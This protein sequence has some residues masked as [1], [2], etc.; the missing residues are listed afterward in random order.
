MKRFIVK[1]FIFTFPVLL[2]FTIEGFLPSSVFTWRPWEALLFNYYRFSFG[3]VFYPYSDLQ[4]NTVGQLCHHTKY[5]ITKMEKW[6]TDKSGNRNDVFIEDPDIL[7]IGDSFVVGGA[8]TQDSTFTKQLQY[9]LGDSLKV[10]NIAPAEFSVLDYYLK[11]KIIKKPKLVIFARSERFI[12]EAMEIYSEPDNSMKSKIKAVLLDNDLFLSSCVF[13]DKCFRMYSKKWIQ[14]RMSGQKGNGLAGIEESNMFFYNTEDNIVLPNQVTDFMEDMKKTKD[15]IISF[16]AYCDSLDID[17]LFLPMPNKASVYY[18]YV[19]LEKQP[20][21][22]F[23]LDSLLR[24]NGIQTFNTLAFYN[25]YRR[26]HDELLYHL[27][28]THWNANGARIFSKKIA[29]IITSK[30]KPKHFSA[31]VKD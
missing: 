22:I 16:K 2:W 26:S 14:A 21:Y 31:T 25:E 30:T 7:L 18:D 19:P 23:K 29:E 24:M 15:R 13:L 1:I 8:L 4:M 20:D 6:K 10:Y 11:K 28:D 17:F 12:P 9:Y 5:S 27:D 3:K